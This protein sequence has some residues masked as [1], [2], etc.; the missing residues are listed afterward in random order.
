MKRLGV[1]GTFVWDRIWTLEDSARGEPFQS[2]GG[3]AYTLATA[4]AVRPA[5]WEVVPIVKVG[6]DLA[7]E[8]HEFLAALPG[9]SVGPS[10]VTVPEPNNR[11]ELR[12]T[13]TEQRGERLTGGVPAWTLEELRPHLSG[14]DALY[15]NFITGFELGLADAEGLRREFPGPL[16]SDLHS[17]FLGC[18]GAR[19]RE[20]R[21]LPHW[22]R[23]A[24]CFD[25]VQ[26]NER[27]LGTLGEPSAGWEPT[28]ERLLSAGPGL[29]V[30]TLGPKGAA[31]LRRQGFPDSPE[32][33]LSRRSS[34]ASLR[35]E[36]RTV[37]L[38]AP[39]AG[40]PTGA[41]DVWG[42]ALFAGLLEGLDL[43][44]AVL[45]AHRT[46]ARK[47]GHRGASSLYAHLAG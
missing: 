1:L 6:S 37:P 19:A 12:Y 20:L 47:M 4:A 36:G 9:V 11:V 24:G 46:A 8:A 29:V 23:W 5:G 43:E 26:L 30:V 42:I 40:D 16:Y 34:G 38:A 13:D 18:P 10:V 32:R 41:G 2:W 27:E 31:Y 33:W 7:P 3:I 17:L 21:T 39:V 14:L 25:A 28:A 44:E 35:A 22:E 15:V 45:R